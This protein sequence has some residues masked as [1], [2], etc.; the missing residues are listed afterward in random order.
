M[1]T[2]YA[3]IEVEPREVTGKKSRALLAARGLIPGIVY[4]AGKP[5][6]PIGVDPKAIIQILK[7]EKGRNSILL[8]LLKGTKAQ[9]HVMVKDYQLN[10]MTNKILHLD[11][12]RIIMDRKVRVSVPI[13]FDGTPL[14]VK[15]EGGVTDV[16]L[17]E[18]LI[19]SLPNDIPDGIH[20][21][22][23]PL[24]IGASV[25]VGDLEIPGKV[26]IVEDDMKQPVILILAPR[27]EAE[28]VVEE[29]EEPEE[30]REAEVA[31][32]GKQPEEDT[33][34]NADKGK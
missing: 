13:V 8:L 2:K 17:R 22:V 32:K 15:N 18:I 16:I 1:A 29:E 27:V 20:V 25:K 10:P 33:E 3:E 28:P 26:R 11:F 14:G 23:T 30:G 21:D 34:K 5:S 6:V 12:T 31:G 7:S 19:E 4:G 24:Q 9:R